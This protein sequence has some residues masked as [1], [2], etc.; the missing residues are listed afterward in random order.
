M[1]GATQG[2]FWIQL[3]NL[4]TLEN[5]YISTIIEMIFIIRKAMIYEKKKK[6]NFYDEEIT[7]NKSMAIFATFTVKQQFPAKKFDEVP[8]N[9]LESF[10][11][12]D[13]FN[14]D[15]QIIINSY[16]I[17]FGFPINHVNEFS[18]KFI[19]FL[20]MIDGCGFKN[21]I[22]FDNKLLL[23]DFSS[24]KDEIFQVIKFFF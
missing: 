13:Y 8:I 3:E 21:G 6:I 14:P 5:G 17:A 11:M 15:I 9:I 1:S 2:G 22:F 7:P 18:E 4:E 19:F 12:I 24:L 10:R 20:K 23:E 16:L